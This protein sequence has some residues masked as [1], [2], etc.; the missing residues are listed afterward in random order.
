MTLDPWRLRLLTQFADRGTVRAVAAALSLSP[1]AVSQQL[2]VLE[3]EARATLLDRHGRRLVLTPDGARLVEHAREIL[4]R[5]DVAERDLAG[6]GA[7]PVGPVRIAAFSSALSA[8]IIPALARLAAAHPLLEPSTVESEPHES[9]PALLRG[10]CDLAVVAEVGDAPL[11][12]GAPMVTVPLVT[13]R[14]VTVVSTDRAAPAGLAELAESPWVLDSASSYLSDLVLRRCRQAGF[15]PR[16][17]ARYRSFGMM[18]QHVEAG[19]A[20]TVL[21]ELAIDPRYRVHTA[22]VEPV[23]RRSVSAALR[24][25]SEPRPAVQVVV[26]ALRRR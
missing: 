19:T 9:V 14:L 7:A 3:R 13:D 11:P 6:R 8:L 24:A 10:E 16:V 26:D 2:T 21:P 15:E 1:S 12:R 22:V 17:V 25:G 18:L 20:V 5:I 23:V 4:D